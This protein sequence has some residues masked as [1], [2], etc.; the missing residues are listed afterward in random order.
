MTKTK[1]SAWGFHQG[2]QIVEGRYALELLG[3]GTN[4]EAYLAWDEHLFSTV[5][6]KVVRPEL[7]EDESVLR[8][9]SNEAAALERLDHPVL[10]RGFGA[11]LDGA[12]PHVVLE[13]IEGPHL[14]RLLR[15]HGPLPLE[16]LLPL[17]LHICSAV[18]YMNREGMLH[19]DVKPRN[20]IIG[21]P[22][23]LIDLSVAR[24]LERAA[25]ITGTV[26]TDAYMAPEQCDPAGRGP[27]G[28]P[29]DVWGIGATLYHAVAGRVPFERPD[30][31]DRDDPG[32]RFPQL[33]GEAPPLDP[34]VV[35]PPLIEVIAACLAADPARR[36]PPSG[37][38]MAL[39]PLVARLPKRRVLR[40]LRPRLR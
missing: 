1:K 40:N 17:G 14:A 16:Q 10:V 24:T 21:V 13:H 6:L 26:G 27:V 39:E 4:Y 22:P 31:Y 33:Q 37:I 38:A 25:A 15:K 9:L 23:K 32:Q 35:P 11:M 18:H 36:P 2:D 8:A 5:V 20:I 34:R 3:G 19:L 30:G 7:V 28:I 29:A 12:R